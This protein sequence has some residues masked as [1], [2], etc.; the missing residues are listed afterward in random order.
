MKDHKPQRNDSPPDTLLDRFPAEER[1]GV[2]LLWEKSRRAQS[3]QPEVSAAETESALR[4]VHQRMD[5]GDA[6][7][8]A[9]GQSA[10][11]WRWWA[12]AAAII[13]LA[14]LTALLLIP[15]TVTVPYGQ[16]ASLQLPD[17]SRIV[18][19]SGTELQYSRLYGYLNRQITLDGEAYFRVR[20]GDHPFSVT[21]PNAVVTVTGT[22]F[23]VRAW[24]DAS[25][26]Q[27][28]VAVDEG[29]VEFHGAGSRGR[30]T[31]QAGQMSR[32]TGLNSPEPAAATNVERLTGW[33]Q[34]HLVFDNQQ[35]SDIFRELE[36]RFDTRIEHDDSS[37]IN[38]TLSAYY[39][40]PKN[41]ER[42]LQD[43]CRVKGLRYEPTADGYHISRQPAGS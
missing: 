20:T 42:V 5:H 16:Q 35:L 37:F 40:D 9:P 8:G 6:S 15:R 12:A 39:T 30:V 11:A 32:I 38:E 2:R 36:R 17:G 43:I 24:S 19:N 4:R 18:L 28:T 14:A 27:T 23:N 34:Q 10:T 7:A 1:A 3:P 13:L 25:R 41:V 21:T 26:L 33:R 29:E 22:R 31:L